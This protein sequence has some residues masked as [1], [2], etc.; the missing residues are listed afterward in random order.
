MS[1]PSI[2]PNFPALIFRNM[3]TVMYIHEQFCYYD[4]NLN[5]E[6]RKMQTIHS[7]MIA[8]P[9]IFKGVKIEEIKGDEYQRPGIIFGGIEIIAIYETEMI[10]YEKDG[11]KCAWPFVKTTGFE[12]GSYSGEFYTTQQLINYL[13]KLSDKL[14]AEKIDTEETEYYKE[15]SHF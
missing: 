1:K 2:F 6:S 14:I 9:R 4:F 13:V 15:E 12:I 10:K 7:L 3:Q 11:K 8:L 5:A